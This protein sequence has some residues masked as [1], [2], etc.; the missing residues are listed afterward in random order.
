MVSEQTLAFPITVLEL[1]VE[2]RIIAGTM[3]ELA[4]SIRK[5]LKVLADPARA[6]KMQAYM[7]SEMPYFGVA[8]VPMRKACKSQFAGL[9]YTS[10]G[11]WQRDVLAIWD[12]AEYREER[13]AAIALTGLRAAKAWQTIAALP[14]YEHMVVTGAWWDFVD[15]IATVR[16][17]V[18][19]RN[20]PSNM[21]HEMRAWS[22]CENNWKRRS[23]ILCQH[24]A[25]HDTD[26]A[27]L[28]D[29]IEPS[30]SSKEFFLR[31]A[32]GWAL[33]E[34]AWSNPDEVARYV[35][36]NEGRLSGL[37]IREALKNLKK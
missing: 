30:I 13:Y 23:A 18:I 29:C 34:Y 14:M 28:Y 3:T 37:S 21:R 5:H 31:K 26:T 15:A 9:H 10:S 33:R 17:P 7:K 12:G 32:I 20:D 1:W 6:P 24:K 35:K 27:F 2:T 25:R 22:R 36:A 4:T 16:F 19:L 8:A 11:D